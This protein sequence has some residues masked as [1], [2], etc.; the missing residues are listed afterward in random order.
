MKKFEV[1]KFDGE[2]FECVKVDFVCGFVDVVVDVF[3]VKLFVVLKK[4]KFKCF[5]VVGG[6]GVNC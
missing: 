5:V 1:V 6:V 3:V 4:M 2:V